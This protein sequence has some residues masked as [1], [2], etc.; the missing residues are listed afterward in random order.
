MQK[1]EQQ[2]MLAISEEHKLFLDDVRDKKRT[3]S[4]VHSKTGKRG[5]VGKMRFPSDIMSRKDKMKH[6]RA[7]KVMTTNIF[8]TILPIDEFKE[9]ETH[10]KK[11]RMQYWRANNTIKEIQKQMGIS[12]Y[13]YY[14]IIDELELPKNRVTSN[15]AKRQGTKKTPK[16]QKEAAVAIQEQPEA[17][18]KESQEVVQEVIVN[19]LNVIFNGTYSAEKIERQLTKLMLLLDGEEEDFYVELKLMQKSKK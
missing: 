9:L 5:Y 8:D 18:A 14:L 17:P 10:E 16:A 12:N 6:R 7:G 4:G 1:R 19:G 2:K 13:D 15:K 11:N 3:A